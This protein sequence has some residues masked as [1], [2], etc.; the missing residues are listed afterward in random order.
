MSL[1]TLFHSHSVSSRSLGISYLSCRTSLVSEPIDWRGTLKRRLCM[2]QNLAKPSGRIWPPSLF[3]QETLV[4]LLIRAL[5]TDGAS[6][7]IHALYC[8]VSRKPR[9]HAR[10]VRHTLIDAW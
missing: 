6:R 8:S 7:D 2:L 1:P 9:G 4:V 5:T 3:P 10:L